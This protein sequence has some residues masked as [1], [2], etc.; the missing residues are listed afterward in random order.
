MVHAER[1]QSICHARERERSG[2]GSAGFDCAADWPAARTGRFLEFVHQPL[3]TPICLAGRSQG[4]GRPTLNYG[5]FLNTVIDFS[6]VAFP[7]SLVVR[8]INRLSKKPP[9]TP[10]TKASPFGIAV[11][12]LNATRYPQCTSELQ[13]G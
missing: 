3:G 11:I 1:I 4:R 10:T 7:I 5:V 12:P 2:G 6:I 13:A 9:V 8:L